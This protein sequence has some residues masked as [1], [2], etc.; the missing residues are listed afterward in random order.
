MSDCMSG[1]LFN[2]NSVLPQSN[3]VVIRDRF[4]DGFGTD[5]SGGFDQDNVSYKCVIS[6]T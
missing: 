2:C 3:A 6:Y 1:V 4:G 5:V